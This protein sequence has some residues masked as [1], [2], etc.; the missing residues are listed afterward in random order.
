M[1]MVYYE[2]VKVTINALGL[3]KVILDMVVW[4]HG[5]SDLI[6]SNKGSLFTL[7]FWLPLCYFSGIKQK[8]LTAFYPQI[9]SYTKR[10]NST[11]EAYLQSFINFK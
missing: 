6:I 4:H 2:L 10:Q 5:F 1:K 7:K 3:A 11:I 9:N 8:L